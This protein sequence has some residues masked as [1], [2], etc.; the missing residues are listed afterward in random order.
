MTPHLQ[1]ISLSGLLQENGG[2]F[3]EDT[4]KFIAF[5]IALAIGDL[6]SKDI[7]YRSLNS[8]NIFVERDGYIRLLNF[9]NS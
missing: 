3:E 5:Q 6:H 7:M 9:E 4:I 8:D 2:H 1:G